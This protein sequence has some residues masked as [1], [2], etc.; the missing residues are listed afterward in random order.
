MM[1]KGDLMKYVLDVYIYI[2]VSGYVYLIL[3]ENVKV[4]L[5]KGIKVFGIIEYGSSMLYFLYVWYF[6]NYKVLLRE[7]YGVIMFYG[8]EVNIIDYEGNLDMEI[9]ILD[10]MDIVIGSIYDEVYKV[11]NSEE[12]IK[13]FVNV[14]KSGKIDII[15]YFGNLGILVDYEKVVRCVLEN[16]VLIEINNSLFII[17]RLGSS[18]NCIKIVLL[19]KEFGV[20]L[21]INSDVYFC[22]KI[23]EFIEVINMLEFI[24][25]LDS[26][27]INK[28]L[29]ELII[30]LK[31]KGRLKDLEL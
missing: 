12:N 20:K 27:I 28:D 24:D 17:F 10:R 14:I 23:G 7:L 9:S 4:V 8:I 15:G 11:G 3:M 19:C 13:V 25:F 26:F 30:R 5:E 6:Y 18:K 22:I 1:K 29:N 31:K 2:I 21:I 16:D